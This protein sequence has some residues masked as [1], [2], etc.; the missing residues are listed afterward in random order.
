MKKNTLYTILLTF[1]LGWGATSCN[2]FLDSEPLSKI[3]PE[4]YFTDASHLQA[5]A[6][7]LYSDILPS[8]GKGMGLFSDAG[9]DNQVAR[10]AEDRYGTGYWRV[11]NEDDDNWNFSRIYKIN[12]FFRPSAS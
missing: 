8:H 12:F 2:D 6:D 5:Y 1:V 7:K 4:Q 10:S 3:S 11:P 9:T